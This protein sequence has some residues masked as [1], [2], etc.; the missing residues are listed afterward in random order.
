MHLLIQMEDAPG[1]ARTL[2]QT[3]A[4]VWTWTAAAATKTARAAWSPVCAGGFFE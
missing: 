4:R 1:S 2:T 3:V